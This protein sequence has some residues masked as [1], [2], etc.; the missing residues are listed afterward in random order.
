MRVKD[1]VLRQGYDLELEA[2]TPQAG[3][4][5][6]I[7]AM[8]GL[9]LVLFL[10]SL[11]QTVVGTAMPQ[12]IAE[13]NG[14]QWYAW[15]ATAYLLAETTAIPIVGKLGDLYGRK[16][17]TIAGVAIFV[18]SS[19]LCGMAN[20]M[21]WLIIWRGVQGLGSGMLFATI[22]ALVADIYPD[23]KDRARYQ[24]LLFSVF[25]VSSVIGPV[26]GGWITDSLNWRW[27]F[28]V[29]LPLGLLA[30]GVLPLVL[31]Q[32]LRQPNA[33]IDYLGALT[34]TI[35]VVALLLAL[36]WV[37][38]GYAW[39]SPPVIGG[40]GVAILSF[41]AFVPLE[42]RAI[43][44]II[45]FSL[46]RNRTIT[47]T[48][49][50]MFMVGIIMF[51][52][53]L[54]T[55]LFVQGVLGLSASGSGMVMIP[56]VITMTLTGILVGQLIAHFGTMKPFLLF[57]TGLMG[58]GIL[59][60]T[61]LQISSSPVLV[62]SFLFV[63]ALG[64]GIINPVTT[65][66][67]QSAV[68]PRVLGVATSATQFIRAIGTTVGTAL[69]GTLVTSGYVA[70]LTAHTPPDVPEQAVIALHS[71]N[72][73][74]NQEALQ[75]LAQLM[76]TVPNGTEVTQALLETARVG[77]ASAIQDGFFFMLGA[78][79]LAFLGAFLIANVHLESHSVSQVIDH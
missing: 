71:P 22:F 67:V 59:L 30:L 29:N 24:G 31:P 62:S 79:I 4:R 42:L 17:I 35:A 68:E 19:A 27:V 21:L 16:W 12:V 56:M 75:N 13:L 26:L 77:L 55:P 76:A 6:K 18:A 41:A 66:A 28:Y 46:F 11:D 61:T 73:L 25:A 65:L 8:L 10:V 43:E 40:F 54:Y 53:I 60:F 5:E 15:V 50:V 44:P 63:F 2:V 74:I 33:R 1:R 72:A 37:G 78:A 58:L 7:L 51:G 20:T 23:L 14:F 69:I 3:R 9:G 36:E 38:A 70:G 64:L 32:S 49:V 48:S 39:S 47:A 45:P 57:G 52:V 34:I